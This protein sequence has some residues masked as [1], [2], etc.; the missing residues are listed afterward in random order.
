MPR[1][2]YPAFSCRSRLARSSDSWSSVWRVAALAW[3][4]QQPRVR[5][6]HAVNEGRRELH[7]HVGERH[8][9]LAHK[10]L[11]H[12]ATK[13]EDATGGRK[14]LREVH[15]RRL[16]LLAQLAQLVDNHPVLA[17]RVTN[18]LKLVLGQRQHALVRR[19]QQ[20]ACRLVCF[21]IVLGK[22]PLRPQQ[23]NATQHVFLRVAARSLRPAVAVGELHQF[24]PRER[25]AHGRVHDAGEGATVQQRRTGHAGDFL[26][27]G[28]VAEAA[29]E[30]EPEV[31]ARQQ[32]QVLIHQ[33]HRQHRRRV[34]LLLLLHLLGDQDHVRLQLL[35]ETVRSPEDVFER[36]GVLLR[37]LH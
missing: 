16:E 30:T 7:I 25:G 27:Q 12:V 32:R 23:V 14:G 35:Y 6:V 21:L 20:E 22:D 8:V 28:V 1:R 19:R 11:H 17:Q 9:L 5:G 10:R 13:V 15:A 37:V 24:L 3:G 33:P 34:G 2:A 4:L 29:G 26:Q 36:L 18:A 31:E